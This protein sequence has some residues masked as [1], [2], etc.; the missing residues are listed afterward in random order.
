M[1]KCIECKNYKIV[2][3][4]YAMC[5]CYNV[6]IFNQNLDEPCEKYIDIKEEVKYVQRT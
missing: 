2:Y 6:K 1:P 5:S 4:N 3:N